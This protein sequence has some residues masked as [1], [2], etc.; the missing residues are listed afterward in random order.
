[1]FHQILCCRALDEMGEYPFENGCPR[2]LPA[3]NIEVGLVWM[4]AGEYVK[5][6]S[7]GQTLR[8]P[9]RMYIGE[10]MAA[11]WQMVDRRLQGASNS[12]WLLVQ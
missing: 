6:P 4:E 9:V 10:E 1:M 2:N 12:R 3:P 8:I 11:I 7:Q 5:P